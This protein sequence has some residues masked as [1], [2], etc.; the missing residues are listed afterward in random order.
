M[1][2]VDNLIEQT[3]FLLEKQKEA[4]RDCAQIFA[5]L[6][7]VVDQKLAQSKG[8]ADDVAS[9]EKIRNLI[10][11]QSEKIAEEA[12]LD[13]DFLNEQLH[14]LK[15]IKEVKDPAKARELTDMLIDSSEE[16]KDTAAFKK[17][18]TD[19]S[20]I[21]KENLMSM[22]NDIKDAIKEGNM[23]DVAM[24]LESVLDISD[25]DACCDDEECEDDDCDDD[26]DD[27]DDNDDHDGE[28]LEVCTCGLGE[29][30]FCTCKKTG[31]KKS[32]GGCGGC[33]GGGCGSGCGSGGGCG[34]KKT[35]IFADLEKYEKALLQEADEKTKH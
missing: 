25:E 11:G 32:G 4:N 29:G 35:D 26:F 27:S 3:V 33:K 13:I 20:A 5:G 22:I 34:T 17:E 30:G 28:E 6:L 24:Y 15:K 18:V 31:S 1:T 2:K 9:L 8:S 19:E 23:Q 10:A 7:V 14:A 21:S 12:Q 16:I